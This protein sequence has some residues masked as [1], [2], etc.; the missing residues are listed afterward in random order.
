MTISIFNFILYFVFL[1][2][3]TYSWF[4][5][6]NFNFINILFFL[7]SFIIT[8]FISG[9]IH[10]FF[11]N[12]VSMENKTWGSLAKPFQE[13]HI[14]PKKITT[15]SIFKVCNSSS[16]IGSFILL[17]NL[18]IKNPSINLFLI[19]SSFLLTITNYIHK[20]SH[21]Y[22]IPFY[23]KILQ[24]LRIILPWEEHHKHHIKPFN[25]CYCITNGICNKFLD[26]Y[27]FWFHLEKIL[28]DIGINKL[29]N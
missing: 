16:I 3:S 25:K 9:V 12:Y 19:T 24:N 1:F 26:K 13:H 29:Q 20:L 23:L 17:I 10:W 15:H 28:E 7:S 5:K 22:P 21:I 6:N 4:I 2:F 11:D 27:G 14:L 8:D 18:F